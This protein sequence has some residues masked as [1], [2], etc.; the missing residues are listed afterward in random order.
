MLFG[1]LSRP[2]TV[3]NAEKKMKQGLEKSILGK[4]GEKTAYLLCTINNKTLKPLWNMG[5]KAENDRKP[6][7]FGAFCIKILLIYGGP[8][9][10]NFVILDIF[11][12]NLFDT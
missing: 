11:T 12:I 6:L 9:I 5:K 3:N 7:T 1:D 2:N 8:Q 4:N 10:G